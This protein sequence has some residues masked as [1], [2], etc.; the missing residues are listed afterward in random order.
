[1]YSVNGLK[2][3]KRELQPPSQR[4][5]SSYNRYLLYFIYLTP[6]A[7]YDLLEFNN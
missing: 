5:L 4:L 3:Y 7:H 6:N 1:M 2:L